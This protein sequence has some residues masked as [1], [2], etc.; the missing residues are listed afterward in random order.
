MKLYELSAEAERLA[1]LLE[2]SE[3][4]L[5]PELEVEW[6]AFLAGGKEKLESAACILR[7]LQAQADACKAESTRLKARSASM[8]A[9]ADRL[10]TLM[11]AAVDGAFNGKLKTDLWTIYGQ[12]SPP[13]ATFELAADA[14]LMRLPDEFVKIEAPRLDTGA[15]WEAWRH[16]QVLPDSVVVTEIP[17]KRSLRVR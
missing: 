15:L 7:S 13:S 8:E 2:Q 12:N 3:G 11:L 10:K 5:S 17:G 6:N 16:K 4:E 1:M 9:N 14:D